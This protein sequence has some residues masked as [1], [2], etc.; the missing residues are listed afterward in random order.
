MTGKQ[1]LLPESVLSYAVM[2]YSE[3]KVTLHRSYFV[4]LYLLGTTTNE[5]SARINYLYDTTS[6]PG[7]CVS[8]HIQSTKYLQYLQV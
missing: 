3:V 7:A 5:P 4:L 8:K 6:R 2:L 1:M